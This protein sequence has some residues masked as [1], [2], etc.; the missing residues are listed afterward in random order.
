[1]KFSLRHPYAIEPDAFWREVFFDPAYNEALYREGLH[2][3]AFK[4]LD[5]S[6]PPDGRRTRKLAVKPKLDAPAA[7][8]KV[9]GDSIDYVEEGRLDPS[10]PAWITRVIPSKLADKVSIHNE[11]WLE[12]TGPGR[13][14]RVASFDVEVKIFGLGGIFEKFLEKTMRESYQLAADFTNKWLERKG[15]AGK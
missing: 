2:F 9:L 1:M 13:S 6:N 12:R 7:I 8:K 14:D 5:E 10:R 11:F 4:V 3:E 15:L